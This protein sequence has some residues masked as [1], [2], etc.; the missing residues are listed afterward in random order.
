MPYHINKRLDFE[1]S[2]FPISTSSNQEH[3]SKSATST[4]G[5]PSFLKNLGLC[6]RIYFL[7]KEASTTLPPFH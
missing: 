6:L 2:S 3:L 7:A 4:P 1:P 5:E